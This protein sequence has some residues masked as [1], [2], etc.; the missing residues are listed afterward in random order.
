MTTRRQ[1]TGPAAT[2]LLAATLLS[3]SAAMLRPAQPGTGAVTLTITEGTSMAAA[4]SPDGR[5]LV[6]DLQ[7]TLWTLPTTGGEATAILDEFH[8]ARQPAWSPDGRTIVFQ[9]YRRGSWDIWTVGRDGRDARALTSGPF[10]DREPHWSPDG[11]QIAFSS[12]RGGNYDIWTLDLGSGDTRQLTE[13]PANDS[14]PAWSPDGREIAFVSRRESSTDVW[15]VRSNGAARRLASFDGIVN[16]PAWRPGGTD[17][18]FNGLVG[19]TSSLV[20]T[21]RTV[22]EGEDVFGFRPSW[23]SADEVVYTADGRIKRRMISTGT[24]RT[25]PFTAELSFIRRPCTQHR[26]VLHGDGRGGQH[27]PHS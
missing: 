9:S 23:L 21:T 8:D 5:T 7:G 12:D 11:G 1:R 6:I 26:R 19:N 24:V 27:R 2:S 16:A 10:D 17:V 22:S 20:L 3:V 18:I 15:A 25:I 14:A 13:H 4:V